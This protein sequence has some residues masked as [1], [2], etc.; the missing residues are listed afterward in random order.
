MKKFLSSMLT[1]ILVL[2]MST[3]AFAAENSDN[4]TGSEEKTFE[5]TKSYVTSDGE[6][7]AVY[8]AETLKFTV[9]VPD[10]STN[11]AGTM[12]KI[13]D[14]T[15]DG[16]PDEIIIT[17]P[18]YTVVGKYNYIVE[19]VKGNTQ[20]VKYSDV[21]FGVQV[22]ASY[23]D[24]HTA[25]ETQVV[26]TT[27]D[28][29]EEGKIDEIKNIYDLGTLEISKDVTGN[30]GSITKEFNV[31]VTFTVEEGMVLKSDITYVDDG[32]EKIILASALDDG[33]ETV[34]ITVK[35]NETVVFSN[36]PYG[37]TYTVK[38]QDYSTGD[39]NSEN[40]YDA[41]KYSVNGGESAEASDG[42]S[43]SADTNKDTVAITNNKGTAVDTGITLDSA[44]YML[45]LVIAAA[46][47]MFFMAKRRRYTED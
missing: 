44:P 15:V 22:V 11:P 31:D 41:P 16:N 4:V 28:G 23:N 33:E 42:V 14:Q 25:I 47:I 24:N 6:T 21:E 43:E 7:P 29:T 19:E 10:D 37:V 32:E 34:V 27:S 8:P 38:E 45:M 39:V 3:V 46:G 17:I 20:G 40:G 18:S 13:E 26:F 30:L 1:A 5:F 9:T 35:D 2:S 12:I 36:I